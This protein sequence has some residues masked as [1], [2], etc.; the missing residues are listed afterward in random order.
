MPKPT[1]CE[2]NG[3]EWRVDEWFVHPPGVRKAVLT[4]GGMPKSFPTKV[5]ARFRNDKLDWRPVQVAVT[6]AQLS[7]VF[8]TLSIEWEDIDIGVRRRGPVYEW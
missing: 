7:P 8:S 1:R 3:E 6:L 4:L 5:D 2:I